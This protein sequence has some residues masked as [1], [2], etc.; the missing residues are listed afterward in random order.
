MTLNKTDTICDKCGCEMAIG[1]HAGRVIWR[2]MSMFCLW[3][4]ETDVPVFAPDCEPR[5]H[6]HDESLKA[7]ARK[8]T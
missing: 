5:K 6:G 3:V 2:C 1:V 4:H 7:L 8:G